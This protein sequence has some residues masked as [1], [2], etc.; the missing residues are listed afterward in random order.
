MLL[1]DFYI[2]DTFTTEEQTIKADIS[3]N[4]NHSVFEGHFPGNPIVPGVTMVQIVKELLGKSVDT[5]LFLD[6]AINIKFM[7]ILNPE[8]NPGVIVNIT[9]KKKEGDQITAASTITKDDKTF[10]KF[11]GQFSPRK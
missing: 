1:R 11:S 2:I 10:F 5:D 6:K 8:E 4:P 9:I 7:A 3:I